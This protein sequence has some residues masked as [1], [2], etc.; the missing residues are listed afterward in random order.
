M[1]TTIEIIEGLI[2]VEEKFDK[3]CHF[4]SR[5][6]GTH[7]SPGA[8]EGDA[9]GRH[10]CLTQINLEVYG[11]IDACHMGD[12]AA[13]AQ[14]KDAVHHCSYAGHGRQLH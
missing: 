5:M 8:K 7:Q 1:S 12:R 2:F 10:C 6:Y 14:A 3:I 4:L 13:T 11:E 9:G